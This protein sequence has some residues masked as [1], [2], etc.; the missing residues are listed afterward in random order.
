MDSPK[1][2]RFVHRAN[3]DQTF[4]SVCWECFLVVGTGQCEADLDQAEQE[5]VCDP[6]TI[7]TYRKAAYQAPK[8]D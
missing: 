5:H 8:P 6:L 1:K 2:R 7:E 4:D 3:R